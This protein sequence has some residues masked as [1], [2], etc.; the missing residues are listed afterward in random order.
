MARRSP[1]SS[2]HYGGDHRTTIKPIG[3]LGRAPPLPRPFSPTGKGLDG[4]E[5]AH[6]FFL[7]KPC[8]KTKPTVVCSTVAAAVGAKHYLMVT[9]EDDA[10]AIDPDSDRSVDPLV[11]P[12]QRE[13][14]PPPEIT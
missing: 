2:H 14:G 11:D 7:T 1:P 5:D 6:P 3:R 10:S 4:T 9:E 13:L 12:F 8:F